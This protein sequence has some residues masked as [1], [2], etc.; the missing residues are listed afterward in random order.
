MNANGK[1]TFCVKKAVPGAI[2]HEIF[3]KLVCV[4][5]LQLVSQTWQH[6]NWKSYLWS[7]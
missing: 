6:K 2:N 3:S 4:S 7:K 5:G 1:N